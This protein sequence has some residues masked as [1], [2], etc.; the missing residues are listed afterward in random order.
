MEQKI[1]DIKNKLIELQNSGDTEYAHQ[2]ADEL[3]HNL[4]EILGYEDIAE[5]YYKVDKWYA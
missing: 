3:V 5:A 2:E 1:L 4:L